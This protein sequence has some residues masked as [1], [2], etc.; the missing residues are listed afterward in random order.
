MKQTQNAAENTFSKLELQN[1]IHKMRTVSTMYYQCSIQIGNH[2]FIEFAGIINEYI[3]CCENALAKG[4]D[5]TI[6]NIHSGSK[7]PILTHNIDYINEKLE[8][9]FT[10]DIQMK[11]DDI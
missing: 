5:F 1:I 10:G 7:L 3:S 6:C 9:I 4:I 8:C 11:R 2:P